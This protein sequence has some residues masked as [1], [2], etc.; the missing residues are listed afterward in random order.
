[1]NKLLE[2]TNKYSL[3][4]TLRFKLEPVGRTSEYIKRAQIIEE[5]ESRATYVIKMKEIMDDYHKNFIDNVLSR[6]SFSNSLLSELYNELSSGDSNNRSQNIAKILG[7]LRKEVAKAFSN[8]K[9]NE[10]KK[11][12][13]INVTLKELH[14][15]DPEKSKVIEK[16]EGFTTYFIP[17]NTNRQNMYVADDKST[18]IAN[19][20]VNQNLIKFIDNIHIFQKIVTTLPAESIE[21]ISDNFASEL[22]GR[23][24]DSFFALDNYSNTLTQQQIATYNAIIGGKKEEGEKTL[25][26]GLNQYVNEY[27]ATHKDVKLPKLNRLFNQILS[28]RV[29]LSETFEPFTKASQAIDSINNAYNMVHCKLHEMQDMLLRLTEYNLEWVYI[30]ADFLQLI[31]QRAYGDYSHIRNLLSEQWQALNPRKSKSEEKYKEAEKKYI[32]SVASL[33]LKQIENLCGDDKVLKYLL[34]LGARN[35]ETRQC[36]NIFAQV[37]NNHTLANEI[38]S[39]RDV[40]NSYFRAN[41]TL[42]K[43][44]LDSIKEA[45]AFVRPLLGSGNEN[46]RDDV[47]YSDFVR[48]Y[49]EIDCVIA[50]LYNKVRNFVTKKEYSTNKFKI[51]FGFPNLL[52]G[53]SNHDQYHGALFVGNAN[54]YYLGIIPVNTKPICFANHTEDTGIKHVNYIYIANPSKDLPN[55]M[56]VDGKTVRKTGKK[57]EDGVNE[58]LEAYKNK[59]LPS[60]INR[61]RLSESYKLSNDNFN[62]E[63]L[64]MFIDYYKQRIIDYKQEISFDFK[65]ARDYPSYD[66]FLND[67]KLQGY[68]IALENVSWKDLNALISSGKLMLFRITGKDFSPN[69]KGLPNLHTIY[70][71]MLFDPENIKDVVYKLSGNAEIFYRRASI[72]K[73]KRV[74]HNANRPIEN[75]NPF[76][77]NRTSTFDYDIIKDRRYT[78]DQFEFHVPI[79]LNY[80]Q[81]EPNKFNKLC[82]DFMRENHIPHIIGIDRGER[83]LLYLVV[84]NDKGEIVEQRSLNQIQSNP[85]IPEF[86]QDYHQLIEKKVGA[87][88]ESRKNW[89]AI[90]NIKEMKEGYM[91]QIVHEIAKLMIKYNAIVVLENLNTQFMQKRGIER[92][93]YQKFEKMLID[94]LGYL[95]D[96]TKQPNEPGGALHALQLA[97]TFANFNKYENGSVRQC[98]FIF[99]IPAWC[100]SKIDPATGFVSMLR[101]KYEGGD[102]AKLFFSQFSKICYDA[103]EDLFSFTFNYDNFKVQSKYGKRCWT[104]YTYG[105]RIHTHRDKKQNNNFV[106][107]SIS[108][109]AEFKN[110][111]AEYGI[112]I[113]GNLKESISAQT[114]EKFFERLMM[115]MRLTLQMRNSS[116]SD[117]LDYIISPIKAADGTFFDSRTCPETM[118]KDADANGAYNIARKGLI[119]LN[120]LYGTPEN[121]KFKPNL[122]NEIWLKFA[123]K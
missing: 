116:A 83:N 71:K 57:N 86:K 77:Q 49:E 33:S 103:N 72:P 95:V 25:Y 109:T 30:G 7:N 3:S 75:K 102:K 118:P 92:S 42:I 99:Y 31:S 101:C 74:I 6:F 81:N 91:S 87:N 39:N 123:Q 9:A 73:D 19:R 16:F 13:F 84:L 104:A 88:D 117:D 121:E 38:L 32:K 120:Q 58:E 93:I 85:L 40:E 113:A 5:D 28:D 1:M 78:R 54:E 111:F 94:K 34:S 122:S 50:P 26:K 35:D 89:T 46:N 47:F 90:E 20:V 12:E 44:L 45:L 66:D 36:E 107:E 14:K 82:L 55:L 17:Y 59:Y 114:K 115:L 106:S 23:N 62:R 65:D 52:S 37:E 97:D 108:L 56:V 43:P 41:S 63:D 48:L 67:V 2:F 11:K 112:D 96:K 29:S 21:Q 76:S 69:S 8:A 110:L 98:G 60:E 105:E 61:I 70:W 51:N 4:K 100:T 27:N 53:W 68:K 64:T 22:Y 15:C 24:L 18:S 10:L 79:M 119:L 80:K